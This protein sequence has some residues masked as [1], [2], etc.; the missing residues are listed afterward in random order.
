MRVTDLSSVAIGI[1]SATTVEIVGDHVAIF[2]DAI[3][4]FGDVIIAR[5]AIFVS[6][7]DFS[8]AIVIESIGTSARS[9]F[10]LSGLTQITRGAIAKRQTIRIGT[11]DV[12]ITIVVFQVITYFHRIGFDENVQSKW[13]FIGALIGINGVSIEE[14]VISSGI[15]EREVE[16][17]GPLYAAAII[18][19]RDLFTRIAFA[20]ADIQN[21]IE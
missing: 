7:I 8:V 9:K 13:T 6:A 19:T 1:R 12:P 3:A 21:R 2:I 15:K 4:A 18:V 10:R 5:A 20:R 16:F 14:D 11:I 17:R